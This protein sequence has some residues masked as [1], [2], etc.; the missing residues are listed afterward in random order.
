MQIGYARV[1]TH[2]QNLGLQIDALKKAGCRK[3]NIFTDT[4][5][6]GIQAKR[7]GLEL[8]MT[9][10]KTGDV[11]VVWKLDRLGRSLPFLLDLMQQFADTGI[12]FKSL[13]DGID[14]STS[15]GKLV[16]HIMG[17]LAEFER[18]LISERT[19]AG[20]AAA[21]RRGKYIGR[22]WKLTREQIL[23]AKSAIAGGETINGMASVLGVHR[24][25]LSRMLKRHPLR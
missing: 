20:I 4:G 6:S 17:S 18:S 14:T 19:K 15:T 11:F 8:A 1:S 3:K 13:Q 23:H 24:S 12:Q 21:K 22:P 2:E 25:T 10:I 16:F 5:I 9:K 7:A